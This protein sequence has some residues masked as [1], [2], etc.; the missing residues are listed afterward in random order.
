V[1]L[2]AQPWNAYVGA[3]VE[4][5]YDLAFLGWLHDFPDPHNY[6]APFVLDG[7]LGGSGQDLAFPE[8]PELVG[9][10]AAE[11]DADDRAA[12][13]E[14]IQGLFAQDVVTIPLWIEHHYI[15]FADRVSGS[16]TFPS[17]ESLNV[18]V[19]Q[20]L[21]YRAIEITDEGEG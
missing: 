4:G 11:S 12:A 20:L 10:A 16:D 15:A 5:T 14:E 8:L 6:L 19:T 9:D 21:D 17:P 18:G 1:T 13:Y 3:V 7:G 2:T